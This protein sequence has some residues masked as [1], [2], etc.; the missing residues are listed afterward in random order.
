M[1]DDQLFESMCMGLS[2]PQI[3]ELY[4]LHRSTIQLRIKKLRKKLA[5]DVGDQNTGV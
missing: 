1:T 2:Q 4:G 5:D 3:A